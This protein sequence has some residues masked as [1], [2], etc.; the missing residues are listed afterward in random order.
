MLGRI[1]SKKNNR[2]NYGT[3]SLPSKR[4]LEW[5]ESAAYQL[6]KH[7]GICI[8]GV[9]RIQ[10]DFYFPDNRKCDLDNKSSSVLDM[11]VKIGILKDDNWQYTGSIFLNPVGIDKKNPKVEIFVESE[12]KK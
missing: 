6:I 2:R 4:F 5:Q 12:R 7:K 11:L 8:E 1:P 9:T 10:M 3:T